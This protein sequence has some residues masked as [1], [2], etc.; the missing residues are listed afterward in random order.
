MKPARRLSD[1]RKPGTF[2]KQL[3]RKGLSMVTIRKAKG[4]PYSPQRDV[5][6]WFVPMINGLLHAIEA[7]IASEDKP[8]FERLNRFETD[9]GFATHGA[10]ECPRQEY[11][12]KLR[13]VRK[14]R[15]EHR[16]LYD[17]LAEGVFLLVFA[18]Y[19][20]GMREMVHHDKVDA[21]VYSR[22]VSVLSAMIGLSS[23]KSKQ[24]LKLF[25]ESGLAGDLQEALLPVE[26]LFQ[27]E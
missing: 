19:T 22:Q 18:A 5:V 8:A 3:K 26:G 17:R 4:D 16:R 11:V 21:D 10:L 12:D 23:E 27:Y 2:N 13:D 9:L 6:N 14:L 24:L 20:R 1:I 15:E 25:A 7:G